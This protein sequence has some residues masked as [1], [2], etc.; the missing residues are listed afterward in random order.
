[1]SNWLGFVLGI[2]FS[3]FVF[4][5]YYQ[6]VKANHKKEI[7]GFI[8]LLESKETLTDEELQFIRT[9]KHIEYR[10]YKKE[11]PCLEEK[12]YNNIE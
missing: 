1:M 9:L 11:L 7:Q 2:V 6:L 10:E 8:Q 3:P 5:G 12:L 4:V